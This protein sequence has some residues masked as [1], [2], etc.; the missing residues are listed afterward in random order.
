MSSA[1]QSAKTRRMVFFAMMIAITVVLQTLSNFI[2]PGG[3]PITLTLI[4]VIIGSAIFGIKGGAALG[5]VAG[6]TVYIT[7]LLGLDK[8]VV[9]SYIQSNGLIS[10]IATPLLVIIKGTVAGIGAGFVYKLAAKKSSLLGVILAGITAPVLN[11]G[12]FVLGTVT[13]FRNTLGEGP[14]W[15]LFLSLLALIWLNFVVELVLDL[16][17]STAIERII[18]ASKQHKSAKN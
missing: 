2:T 14:L 1:T 4:P 12:I 5:F 9:M 8:G 13:I 10:A 18:T 15:P 17:L 6:L 7:G 3:I 16:V 11:T